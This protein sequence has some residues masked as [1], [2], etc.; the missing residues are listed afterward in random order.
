MPASRNPQNDPNKFRSKGYVATSA[1]EYSAHQAALAAEKRLAQ[2][3][4]NTSQAI[5]AINS[6]NFADPEVKR[7]ALR[8][9]QGNQDRAQQGLQEL[10]QAKSSG[11]SA[12]EIR[13][14][15]D[16][17]SISEQT[18]KQQRVSRSHAASVV[19][20]RQAVSQES[21]ASATWRS[22]FD[23]INGSSPSN[24]IKSEQPNY[25]LVSPYLKAAQNP[26]GSAYNPYEGKQPLQKVF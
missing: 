3:A 6:Q 18:L 17:Y 20:S 8:E 15:H 13:K 25:N 23:K 16:K 2:I 26:K 19:A 4:S 5:G 10:A 14:I 22:V 7:K 11:A 12:Q 9:Q 21:K 24:P 1:A